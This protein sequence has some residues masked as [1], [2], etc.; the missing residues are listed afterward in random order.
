MDGFLKALQERRSCYALSKASPVSGEALETLI[1]Q[2]VL[3]VAARAALPEGQGVEPAE[4]LV[5]PGARLSGESYRQSAGAVSPASW[6]LADPRAVLYAQLSQLSLDKMPRSTLVAPDS[7]PQNQIAPAI[8]QLLGEQLSFY[9]NLELIEPSQW[10]QRLSAGDWQLAILSSA[11]ISGDP[12]QLLSAFATGAAGNLAAVSLPDYDAQ[13]SQAL[14][15][16]DAAS[17]GRAERLL[18]DAAALLPLYHASTYLYCD[19]RL[20]GAIY[21]PTT[22]A[23]DLTSLTAA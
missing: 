13:L 2:A 19:P 12:Q 6:P 17:L 22:G 3:S 5:P 7:F 11:Q 15:S 10:P 23:L 1:R 4:G 16:G 9:I 21:H 8:Q 20:S 18:V 14:S